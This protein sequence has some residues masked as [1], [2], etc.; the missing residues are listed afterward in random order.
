[1]VAEQL[2]SLYDNIV[3]KLN[4]KLQ[5]TDCMSA[6]RLQFGYSNKTLIG[7]GFA[8]F[9]LKNDSKLFADA[10]ARLSFNKVI[11]LEFCIQ[12]K[13][14]TREWYKVSV[15]LQK[16]NREKC[17]ITHCKN[18]NELKIELLKKEETI[19]QLKEANAINSQIIY[20]SQAIIVRLD[21][22]A[23][24]L[25]ISKGAESILGYSVKELEGKNWFAVVVPQKR[26]PKLKAGF[27]EFIKSNANARIVIAQVICKDGTEKTISW[28]TNKVIVDNKL[29][30]TI[31]IGKDITELNNKIDQL[32]ESERR[33]RKLAELV[34]IPV[35]FITTD[36]K[37]VFFNK[38]Y[39]K[40][41][42]FSIEDVPDVKTLLSV[43]YKNVAERNAAFNFWK[44][45]VA[46]AQKGLQIPARELVVYN[47]KGQRKIMRYSATV[48]RQHIYYAYLDVTAQREKEY[49]L[50]ASKETFKRIAEHTPI[51]VGGCH[52]QTFKL[53]FSN[54]KFLEIFGF[55]YQQVRHFKNWYR[56]IIYKDAKE[57]KSKEE[58]WK[59]N[60][61]KLINNQQK[62]VKLLERNIVCADKVVRTFEIGLTYDNQTIYAF[63]HDVTKRNE[64]E[65]RLRESELRFRNLAELMLHP[66]SFVTVDGKFVFL[67]YQF[68]KQFGYTLQD[69]PDI[70]TVVNNTH[71]SLKAKREG[72][73]SWEKEV[74]QLFK[75]QKPVTK[76]V[77][78]ETKQGEIKL[79]EY[80]ATLSG[81]YVYYVYT[82][83]TEQLNREEQL[84]RDKETFKRIAENT[85][86]AVTG[87]NSDTFDLVY[88]NKKF[89]EIVGYH[90]SE[91]SAFD[92]WF[93]IIVHESTK[94]KNERKKTWISNVKKMLSNKHADI[95]TLERNI[96]C[97]NG[98]VKTFEIGLT[99]DENIIYAFFY[100]ITERKIA[101]RKL[102]ES[103]ARFRNI[104]ENI[105]IPFVTIDANLNRVYSNKKH[106]DIIGYNNLRK[107]SNDKLSEFS[108]DDLVNK[109]DRKKFVSIVRKAINNKENNPIYIEPYQIQILCKDKRLHTFE[110]TETIFGHTIYTAFHDITEKEIANQLLKESEQRFKALAEN[111]PIAIGAYNNKDQVVFV[112]NHFANITGYVL[113]DIATVK[114]WY[115]LTQ[116][117][118]TRR[119]EFY[120]YWKK[121]VADFKSGRLKVKPEIIAT[122]RCKDGSF[123]HFSFSFSID[124]NITYILILDIT[125]QEKAKKQLQKSYQELRNLASYLQNVREEERKIIS[126][127]IHDELGQQLTGIKMD[128]SA[129]FRKMKT[130]DSVNDAEMNQVLNMLNFSVKT[131]RKISSQLRPS[132]L[133]DLGL[134][135][136]IEW[137]AHE[138]T[139]RSGVACNFNNH[140]T[141]NELDPEVQ[142]NL[143][144]ILQEAL[145]NIM[146]H[147]VA[148]NVEIDLKNDN[149]QIYL[150][151][152]DNG[153]GFNKN[154]PTPTLG[155]LGM[156]ERIL[157]INGTFSIDS[158]KGKGTIIRIVVPIK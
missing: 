133:D 19:R 114:D 1:M 102:V 6:S 128:V 148:K 46:T 56:Y 145:T 35:S 28:R 12:H 135:A 62:E 79:V 74:E 40:Q 39:T 99:S 75:T 49:L 101:E 120:N 134:S 143:F 107:T 105:P 100:D 22:S 84:K 149:K 13:N 87:C 31:G 98:S 125:E 89:H 140:L 2:Y 72:I 91:I 68:T 146:R 48:N 33:F 50:E 60:I 36:G 113:G 103:E 29:L 156:K 58:E 144:R 52:Y 66:V 126:R 109:R 158:S 20:S 59:Q 155:L 141:I 55:N 97:K 154:N 11:D 115:K 136:A 119:I 41:F 53:T 4:S 96:I 45:D 24:I 139:K 93:N 5:I 64:S 131:V 137:Q 34:P 95:P 30:C 127:E 151:I 110:I 8:S 73:K 81:N 83:I 44:Q 23:T 147:A 104:A 121:T 130:A 63:F 7:K 43:S 123:K 26:F 92:Q 69:F 80:S 70:K 122:A 76:R 78:V 106:H 67:N 25:G 16:I 18:I 21:S 32:Q 37:I 150:T 14:K 108:I 15:S 65:L 47:K 117:H 51:A 129:I 3:F 111:M 152:A 86:V 90:Y 82:D 27:M 17:I 112:N 116:P 71:T 157:M 138:F 85:P 88:S 142:S 94:Q 42:G 124:E 77:E 9:L 38:T 132:M 153:K 61:Y 10:V 118:T 57:K 54:Q